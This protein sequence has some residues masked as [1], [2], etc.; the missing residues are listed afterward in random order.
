MK[1]TYNKK[2]IDKYSSKS[3]LLTESQLAWQRRFG[4]PLPTLADTTRR[5]AEKRGV[6]VPTN[7]FNVLDESSEDRINV[8]EAIKL[9]KTLSNGK[10]SKHDFIDVL[11][12]IVFSAYNNGKLDK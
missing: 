4:E 11:Q 5:Y 12:E 2:T 6:T 9:F 7:K 3:S 8:T 1:Q 10:M